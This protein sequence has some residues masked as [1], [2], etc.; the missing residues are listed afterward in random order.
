MRL[1]RVQVSAKFL[2]L[3]GLG[4]LLSDVER[5]EILNAYQYD[6]RNFFSMQR[7]I[8]QEGKIDDLQGDDLKKYARKT[9]GATDF[10]LL[11][12]TE[13]H[14]IIC[15]MRQHRFRGFWTVIPSGPWALVPPVVVDH[16]SAVLSVIATESFIKRIFRVLKTW[17]REFSVLANMVINDYESDLMLQ[18]RPKFTKRQR[19]IA[20][21]AVR[22][23]FYETP[24]QVSARTIADH[25]DIT[26][27]TMNEHLRKAEKTAM[28]F[29]FGN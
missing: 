1:L 9:F 13:S 5:V 19:E 7:I 24:K 28:S 14:I 26:P 25:F 23:G 20:T 8:F 16:K 3:M 10:D 21:Y 4:D 11:E 6:K 29:L 17:A 12:R 2:K 18:P 22:H 27:S 15:M